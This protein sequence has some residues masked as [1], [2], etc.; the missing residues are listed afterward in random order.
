MT[1]PADLTIK[2]YPASGSRRIMY[3]L[4]PM[5]MAGNWFALQSSHY[6]VNI[7]VIS[8]MDWDNDLTPWPAPGQPPGDPAF[9]GLAPQL[10][11]TFLHSVV[12]SV[13]K[14]LGVTMPGRILCGISLSGLFAVWA[15]TQTDV[16][17][18]IISIS[19]SFWYQNFATWFATAPMPEIEG[20]KVYLS[21]GNKEPLSHVKA[22]QSVGTATQEVLATFERH[23]IVT[24]FRWEPGTH[25]AAP[26]PRLLHA[27]TY[28]FS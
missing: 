16:F 7:A 5:M 23:G 10:L 18:N 28:I 17:T 20:G 4:V 24:D 14:K 26:E 11:H 22:F 19:G 25:Y 3:V 13:E 2:L 27:F 21:L 6:G 12:P 1:K 9:K 8:G 15:R